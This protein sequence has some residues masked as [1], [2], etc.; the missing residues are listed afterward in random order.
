MDIDLTFIK[1]ESV[2]KLSK[3][4]NKVKDKF[5]EMLLI[6]LDTMAP[7]ID[8]DLKKGIESTLED[9][10][11]DEIKKFILSFHG[12]MNKASIIVESQLKDY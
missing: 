3:S 6:S 4:L 9:L 2:L 8:D 1:N 12:T 7:N 10:I 5:F 11:S